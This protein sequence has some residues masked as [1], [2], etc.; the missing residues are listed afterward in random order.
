MKKRFLIILFILMI[1]PFMVNAQSNLDNTIKLVKEDNYNINDAGSL[2]LYYKDVKGEYHYYNTIYFDKNITTKELTINNYIY[3]IKIVKKSGYELNLDEVTMD[4]KTDSLYQKK[5]SKT[6]N[7]VIEVEKEI[8]LNISGKGKL[9]ISARSPL[10]LRGKEYAFK[11]PK[12]NY[13][14]SIN[15]NS[16]FIEYKINSNIGSF[17]DN[18]LIIPNREYLF[19]HLENVVT[20]SGHPTAPMDYYVSNDDNY[21]YIFTEAFIDNTFDHGKDYSKVYVKTNNEIK[22]YQVNTIDENEYGKWWFEYTNSDSNINW[23]HMEY[24]IKIP[25]SDIKDKNI[26]LLFEYY[27]TATAEDYYESYI[28]IPIHKTDEKGNPLDGATFTLKDVNGK[29]EFKSIAKEDGDYLIEYLDA[30]TPEEVFDMLPEKYQKVIDDIAESGNLDDYTGDFFARND[31]QAIDIFF[32]MYIEETTPPS[33]Y[34]SKKI[35]VPAYVTFYFSIERGTSSYGYYLNVSTQNEYIPS[36]YYEYN[37]NEDYIKIFDKLNYY[38]STDNYNSD[39]FNEYF[40]KSGMLLDK[41]ECEIEPYETPGFSDR[42]DIDMR[43]DDEIINNLCILQLED[44]KVKEEIKVNP[45]TYGTLT[46]TIVLAVASIGLFTARKL[47]KN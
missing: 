26:G 42:E 1:I 25:M 46:V 45:E 40:E 19:Y 22:E 39:L 27:G 28:D 34:E 8:Y 41:V 24:L 13:G 30:L 4:Y 21:L 35:V 3:G 2:D 16:N 15:E 47:R 44:E 20:G 23:Q 37:E 18:N 29:K 7:D 43:F 38:W 32:P 14:T 11:F 5:L 12:D 6:D 17:S 33:G 36:G 31:E 10:T 9:I